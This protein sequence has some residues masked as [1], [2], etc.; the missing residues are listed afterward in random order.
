MGQEV[1]KHLL[2]GTEAEERGFLIIPFS[3]QKEY[4][5]KCKSIEDF[6]VVYYQQS[7]IRQYWQQR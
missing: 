1:K 5:W 2:N 6:W 4:S 3:V 7:G